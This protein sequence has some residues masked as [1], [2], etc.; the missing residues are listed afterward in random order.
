MKQYGFEFESQ[1]PMVQKRISKKIRREV[2]AYVRLLTADDFII[3][4]VIVY[5]SQVRGAA[6]RWSDIDVCII[7]PSFSKKNSDQSWDYLLR[8]S[9]HVAGGRIEPVGFHPTQFTDADPLAWEIKRTGVH[10]F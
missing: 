2:E 9:A 8:K 7:S 1:I 10:I 5:G 3:D 4:Q 6:N